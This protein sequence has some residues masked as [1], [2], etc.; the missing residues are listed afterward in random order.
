V[1]RV[2][3]LEGREVATLVETSFGLYTGAAP[4]SSLGDE[5]LF[6]A[7]DS[8]ARRPLRVPSRPPA[9]HRGAGVDEASLRALAEAGGGR[10]L[11]RGDRPPSAGRAAGMALAPWLLLAAIAAFCV[12]RAL[13]FLRRARATAAAEGAAAPVLAALVLAGAGLVGG[14]VPPRP[15]GDAEPLPDRPYAE[16]TT[17]QRAAIAALVARLRTAEG[18]EA[19]DLFQRIARAGESALPPLLEALR[20]PDP[21]LRANAAYL[22]GHFRDRRTVPALVAATADPEPAVR[23]E[24]A[25]ALLE[26]QDARGFAVLVAGLE[27]PDARLRAKCRQVLVERAGEDLGFDPAGPPAARAEAVRRWRAWLAQRGLAGG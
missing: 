27:D 11:A 25:A 15:T 6:A 18:A 26:V 3:T 7:D 14:C 19:L 2:R 20:D 16:G 8:G 1:L 17:E 4:G 24:A 9:E 13:L 10:R 21:A 12:E 23:Y 22:L 5:P